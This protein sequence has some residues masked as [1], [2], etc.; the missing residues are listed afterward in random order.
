MPRCLVTSQVQRNKNTL[1]YRILQE[2]YDCG[3]QDC[4][5]AAQKLT[6]TH[7]KPPQLTAVGAKSLQIQNLKIL[8]V[9]NT[10]TR[11]AFWP[12]LASLGLARDGYTGNIF[13]EGN[14]S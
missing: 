10:K 7:K 6:G 11:S 2:N 13:D 1:E 5:G 12:N 9:E 14:D 8:N 3:L 4:C